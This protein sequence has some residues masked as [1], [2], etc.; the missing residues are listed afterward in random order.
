MRPSKTLYSRFADQSIWSLIAILKVAFLIPGLYSLY[1]HD[2]SQSMPSLFLVHFCVFLV[3][4][5]CI[6]GV[7]LVYSL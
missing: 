5:L 6:P 2:Q 3:Y 4:S 1:V 7:L